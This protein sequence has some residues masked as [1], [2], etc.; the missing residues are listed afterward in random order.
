MKLTVLGCYGPYPA[1]GGACSGYLLEEEGCRVLIDCGSGVLSRLQR[2]VKSW[3]LEA[4]I[5]SH[6]HSDH[7][8][9]LMV[10]RY[11]LEYARTKGWRSEPLRLY[12]PPEP[13]AVLQSLLYRDN[14]EF[15]T[16]SEAEPLQMGPFQ[17]TFLE[18]IHSLPCLAMRVETEKG[19]LVYSGD[20]EYFKGLVD[21]AGGAAIFLCEAN[22]QEEDMASS[23]SNHLSAAGAARIAARAGVKR[24]LLTHL[25]PERDP[26]LSL[27]E[28]QMHYPAAEIAREGATYQVAE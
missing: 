22:F 4:V 27:K 25:H 14:F 23:P 10:M 7:T 1:A 3:E 6:L 16:L 26:A 19:S 21:F 18:T 28:A 2:Y 11:A 24:L 9:D 12:S 15:V 17:F 13:S 8:A 20:T 5:L